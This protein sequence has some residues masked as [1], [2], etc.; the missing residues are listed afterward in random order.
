[1]FPTELTKQLWKLNE[2]DPWGNGEVSWM[3]S[4]LG[5]KLKHRFWMQGLLGDAM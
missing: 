2:D 5:K 3:R 4:G 1:M